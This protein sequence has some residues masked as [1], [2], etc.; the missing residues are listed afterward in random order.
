[1]EKAQKLIEHALL[2][3]KDFPDN[4]RIKSSLYANISCFYERKNDL[5]TAKVYS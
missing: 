5:Q 3:S 4:D 1:M 2:L